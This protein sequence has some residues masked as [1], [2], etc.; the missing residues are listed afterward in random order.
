VKIG[1]QRP[2]A[3]NYATG[4]GE[5]SAI[6]YTWDKDLMSTQFSTLAAEFY[7]SSRDLR[8]NVTLTLGS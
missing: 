3:Y 2:N 8:A 7:D 5:G 4:F 6:T 1:T